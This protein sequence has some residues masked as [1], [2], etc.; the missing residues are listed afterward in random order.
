MKLNILATSAFLCL[1]FGS[2]NS[3]VSVEQYISWVEENS[4][5]LERSGVFDTLNIKVVYNT[6]EKRVLSS[7]RTQGLDSLYGVFKKQHY[8][9]VHIQAIGLVSVFNKLTISEKE[10]KEKELI[11]FMRNS[12]SL[13]SNNENIDIELFHYEGEISG[14]PAVIGHFIYPA[15]PSEMLSFQVRTLMDSLNF[16]FELSDFPKLKLD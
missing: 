8:F 15:N 4:Y 13:I 2:C 16:N 10:K 11:S 5:I 3:Y 1:F 14:K 6:P 12:F 7:N 9:V